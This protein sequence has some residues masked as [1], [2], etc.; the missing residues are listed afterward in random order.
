MHTMWKGSISFGLVN[1]PIKLFSATEDKDIK[2]RT[3]HKECHTPIKYE[4][5]C[6]NCQKEVETGELVKG[7]EYVK[8][9]FVIL[10]EE[11]LNNLKDEHQEKSVEIID[12]VNLDEIDPIY[13]SRSYFMGPGENGNKAYA[14]LRAALQNSGKIGLAEITIRTKRQMAVVRVY[15]NTL[16]METIHYPD[17]VRSVEEVPSVPDNAQIDPKELA[18]AIMLIDQLTAKFQPEKY[19]DEYRLRVNELIQEKVNSNEGTSSKEV[20][21]SNVVDLMSA[22]QASIERTKDNSKAKN[23]GNKIPVNPENNSSVAIPKESDNKKKTRNVR[24]KA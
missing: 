15:Q 6:P 19:I 18:T 11:E 7:Y 5:V 16:I 4:K 24:K 8:G 3:L 20:S 23:D 17:E 22:L 14:L 12:F 21:R 13:F 2:L 10:S 1:I 9:K